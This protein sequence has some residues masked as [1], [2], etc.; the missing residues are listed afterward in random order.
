VQN[1][2]ALRLCLMKIHTMPLKILSN[3]KLPADRMLH[4]PACHRLSAKISLIMSG[5]SAQDEVEEDGFGRAAEGD[6][7][8]TGTCQ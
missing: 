5:G 8:H 7:R 3:G 6:D 1:G 4:L 2:R